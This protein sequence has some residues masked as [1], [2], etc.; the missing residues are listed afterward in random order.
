MTDYTTILGNTISFIGCFMMVAI[1]FIKSKRKILVAQCVQFS[2]QCAGHLV[3]GSISGGISCC[4]NILRIFAFQ[5]LKVTV[6]LKLGFL[7]LQ[8]ALILASRPDNPVQW[9]PLLAALGYT[10]YLDTENVVTFKIVNLIGS[11]CWILHDLYYSNYVAAAFDVMT[12]VSLS[13]GIAMVLRD[14]KKTAA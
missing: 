1:G 11:A 3:L 10:W 4:V 8:A 6:W 2:F 7:A 13:M 5:K 9:L 14:R 12:I